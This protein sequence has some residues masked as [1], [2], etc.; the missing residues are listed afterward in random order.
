MGTTDAGFEER[1]RTAHKLL[2]DALDE[3][4]GFN[5]SHGLTRAQLDALNAARDHI[6]EAR[7]SLD[8]ASL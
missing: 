7:E 5:L 2:G 6:A 3:V 8:E 1:R 4:R